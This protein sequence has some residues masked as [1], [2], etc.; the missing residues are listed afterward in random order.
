VIGI[1]R[2][3]G[4]TVG[5]RHNRRVTGFD[6]FD[7]PDSLS[8]GLV[9]TSD[10]REYRRGFGHKREWAMFEFA[11]REPFRM[12]VGNLFHLQCALERDR[13]VI[14]TTDEEV[15]VSVDVLLGDCPCVRRLEDGLDLAQNIP[16][17][18]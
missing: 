13:I 7:V 16:E 10:N 11:S 12:S 18:L 6:F 17:C 15:G 1:P 5:D 9:V 2:H 8:G 4:L 14:L 3:I